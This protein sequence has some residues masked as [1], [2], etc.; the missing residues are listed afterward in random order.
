VHKELCDDV[1]ATRAEFD[2]SQRRSNKSNAESTIE[3]DTKKN[4]ELQSRL[5]TMH[6]LKEA[7]LPL[8]GDWD[9]DQAPVTA[10]MEG[11]RAQLIPIMKFLEEKMSK[12]DM[13][14]VDELV[15][16]YMQDAKEGL[17]ALSSTQTQA[18]ARALCSEDQCNDSELEE[19]TTEIAFSRKGR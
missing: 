13:G 18:P 6:A 11:V 16:I 7:P 19:E 8:S 12:E 9:I 14:K 2:A 5:M 3:I 4:I 15:E 10:Y 17:S 1:A